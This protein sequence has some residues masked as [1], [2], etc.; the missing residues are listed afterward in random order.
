M[1]SFKSK[2]RQKE[3]PTVLRYVLSIGI[4]IA[5]SIALLLLGALILTKLKDPY[6]VMS[7]TAL[8]SLF[9][10]SLVLGGVSGKLIGEDFRSSIITGIIFSLILLA[11][12]L[13]FEQTTEL[14]LKI[15]ALCLVPLISLLGQVLFK[16]RK[17][18]NPML[19]R[20]KKL[21]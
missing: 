11:A 18:K 20:Y 9:V 13:F 12:S 8:V 10:S 3:I 15:T 17:A 14:P 6:G 19:E 4:G 7:Y 2:Y 16:K 5:V 21:R 1:D